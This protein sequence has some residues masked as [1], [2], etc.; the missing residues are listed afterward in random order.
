MVV[1]CQMGA[2]CFL[3]QGRAIQDDMLGRQHSLQGS[4]SKCTVR[5]RQGP[6]GP[7]CPG[8]GP[9]GTVEGDR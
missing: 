6:W 8:R 3:G 9:C 4:G 7:V 1:H 2:F 5:S